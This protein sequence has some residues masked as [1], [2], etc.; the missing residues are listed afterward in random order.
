[1]N[2]NVFDFFI[3]KDNNEPIKKTAVKFVLENLDDN[4]QCILKK[5]L[6]NDYCQTIKKSLNPIDY[7]NALNIIYELNDRLNTFEVNALNSEQIINYYKKKYIFKNIE[8]YFM[9]RVTNK[10]LDKSVTDFILNNLTKDETCT[11]EEGLGENFRNNLNYSD[12][13]EDVND[14]LT[15]ITTQKGLLVNYNNRQNIY[16]MDPLKLIESY[17]IHRNLKKID[18]ELLFQSNILLNQ[19]LLSISQKKAFNYILSNFSYTV[20]CVLYLY[21]GTKLNRGLT[22]YEISNLLNIP[23]D[24][25]CQDINLG[26]QAYTEVAKVRKKYLQRKS[27]NCY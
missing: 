20:A 15:I 10:K 12:E 8:D 23:I 3:N 11:L 18:A 7:Q 22:I 13:I 26:K 19:Y 21:S 6:G 1:M 9:D 24:I 2:T 17:A 25:V 16:E 5:G 27:S 4:Q 14:A